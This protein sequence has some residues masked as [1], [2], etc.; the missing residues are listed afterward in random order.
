[1]TVLVTGFEPFGGGA[2]NPSQRIV[3]SLDGV[4]KALLP[5]SYARAADELRRA[6]SETTA[7]VV[8]CF[9]QADGRAQISIERF[10]HNLD[11]AATTDNDE[12]PGSGAAIDPAGPAAY[13]STLPVDEIV[14]ALRADGIP[15]APSRDAGGFLCN[16]VFYVLMRV[17][18]EERPAAIG[19]FVHV[20]L[21]PEQALEKDA[22]TMPLETQ[23]RA[24][25][26][27][28]R[29]AGACSAAGPSVAA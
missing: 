21:L 15:A 12:A 26:I 28:V 10:A 27:V 14:E 7:D 6:V 16:H 4:A 24:A 29:T 11:E 8:I 9:G 25:T 23:L 2:T 18:E 19:G 5:V 13:A 1:V 17:L 3:E 22:P 20:P